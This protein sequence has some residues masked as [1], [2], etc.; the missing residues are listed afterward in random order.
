M[1]FGWIAPC[2]CV[3]GCAEEGLSRGPRLAVCCR[4]YMCVHPRAEQHCMHARLHAPVG[5][6]ST[7]PWHARGASSG[8]QR[9]SLHH[10]GL[11][12]HVT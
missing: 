11:S 10:T 6:L 3:H 9:G 4:A 5:P 1:P 8:Q 12:P 7:R 2:A